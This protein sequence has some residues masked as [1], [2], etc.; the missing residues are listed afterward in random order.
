MIYQGFKS[1]NH[2]TE[3]KKTRQPFFFLKKKQIFSIECTC[4]NTSLDITILILPTADLRSKEISP[5]LSDICVPLLNYIW[6]DTR[7]FKSGIGLTLQN[8]PDL[9]IHMR[10]KYLYK[11]KSLLWIQDWARLTKVFKNGAL[12]PSRQEL[13]NCYKKK[14]KANPQSF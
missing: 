7:I 3:K 5:M 8:L 1:N 4:L 11:R 9:V 2:S 10:K 14:G 6:S 13:Q 12:Y